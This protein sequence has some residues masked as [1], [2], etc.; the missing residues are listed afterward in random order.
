[1]EYKTLGNTGLLVSTLCLG[2]M[3]FH[4]GE[5]FWSKIGTVDQPGADELIKTSIEAGINFFD[6]ADVYSEGE[7]EKTLG[8]SLKNLNIARK[9]VV[10]ATKVYGRVGP[11]RNDVGA[12][13]ASSA[14]KT[15]SPQ[16]RAAPSLTS[17]WSTRSA[18]GRS[19]TSSLPSPRPTIAP[20]PAS[21]SRGCSPSPSSPRSS[22][23]PSV[24]TNSPTTSPRSTLNSPKPNSSNSTKSARSH[25]ST[26][27]G[28]F[29]SRAQTASN[30]S[31][32][33]SNLNAEP[34]R[35]SSS[36]LRATVEIPR[37]LR[38]AELQP[39][40]PAAET[41]PSG[42][43]GEPTAAPTGS[44]SRSRRQIRRR[45]ARESG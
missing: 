4:G 9:D 10:I 25:R 5:G 24:R 30:L 43:P 12:S 40:G 21:R 33:R 11:G 31:L 20:P 1:M 13:P 16:A 34:V 14:A 23:G 32:A 45:T 19:S 42:A 38:P 44:S 2:T 17:P 29:R 15:K 37:W 8:Q 22:S 6:T 39:L 3:T 18:P 7:S 27:A 26:P 35:T 28:C 41:A 36:E